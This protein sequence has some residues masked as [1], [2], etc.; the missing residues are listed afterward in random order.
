MGIAFSN[1]YVDYYLLNQARKKRR[2]EDLQKKND[3]YT[4]IEVKKNKTNR[5]K[6]YNCFT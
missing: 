5:K 4:K 6:C 3:N 2:E 1:V